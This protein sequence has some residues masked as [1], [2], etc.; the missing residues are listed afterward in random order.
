MPLLRRRLRVLRD[1]PCFFSTERREGFEGPCSSFKASAIL[2]S[3]G[4][5]IAIEMSSL[6]RVE[7][8]LKA[9]GEGR[10]MGHF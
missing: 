1:T 6:S 9:F 5:S 4:E 3:K 8:A 2:T 7:G 10:I